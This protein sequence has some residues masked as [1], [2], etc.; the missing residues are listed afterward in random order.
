MDPLV[1]LAV[2]ACPLGMGVMMWMMARGMMG[3]RNEDDSAG[4]V[5]ELRADQERLAEEVERLERERAGERNV[6]AR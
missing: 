5:E 2:L 6:A 1:L 3:G 4:E